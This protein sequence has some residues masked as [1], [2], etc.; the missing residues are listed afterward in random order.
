[1]SRFLSNSAI[2]EEIGDLVRKAKG[3]VVAS[4]AYLGT[5][6][7]RLLPLRRSDILLVDMGMRCV[8]QGATNPFEVRKYVNRHVRVFTRENLH[9][10]L[11]LGPTFLVVG[12]AN[13]SWNSVHVLDEAAL[14]T[15]E[16]EVVSA[17]KAFV[18]SMCTEPVRPAYLKLCEQNYRPPNFSALKTHRNEERVTRSKLWFIPKLHWIS[19]DDASQRVEERT[20]SKL[21]NPRIHQAGWIRYVKPPKRLK[22]GLKEG[23]WVLQVFKDHTGE[24]TVFAP[25]QFIGWDEERS[26][27][28]KRYQY[29]CLAEP[30]NGD[31]VP[32]ND[33]LP[34]IARVAPGA[35]SAGSRSKRILGISTCDA[36]LRLWNRRGIYLPGFNEEE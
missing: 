7:S 12:S 34:E 19:E 29:L 5:E 27:T 8:R 25:A 28:G 2:W 33:V 17:A 35:I 16:G 26:K 36:I 23:D 21:D 4:V 6:A 3:T 31:Q 11:I 20:Q 22:S 13:A 1:M 9:T 15:R 18:L 10:K 24:E 32:W 30:R 14:F